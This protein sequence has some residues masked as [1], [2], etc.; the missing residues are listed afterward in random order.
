MRS[1]LA[2]ALTAALFGC[3]SSAPML[4]EATQKAITAQVEASTDSIFAA[5]STLQIDSLLS[6]W[7]ADQLDADQGRLV[8]LEGQVDLSRHLRYTRFLV[9]YPRADGRP[10]PGA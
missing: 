1:T 8:T 2:I 5:A 6:F 10:G 9:L 4:D 7:T 3:V